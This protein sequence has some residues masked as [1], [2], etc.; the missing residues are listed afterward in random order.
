MMFFKG[1][2]AAAVF[3]AA[4]F[5]AVKEAKAADVSLQRE[6]Q[7]V[8]ITVQVQEDFAGTEAKIMA[9]EAG[10]VE[11]RI[12][13]ADLMIDGKK[14]LFR[15]EDAVVRNISVSRDGSDGIIRFNT[16]GINSAAVAEQLNL[17]RGAGRLQISIPEELTPASPANAGSGAAADKALGVASGTFSG[18]R[19]ATIREA[20]ELNKKVAASNSSMVKTNSGNANGP[21]IEPA[22]TGGATGWTSPVTGPAPSVGGGR[23]S[24]P[25]S[26]IPV[27]SA[28]VGEKKQASTGI[29][30]L[31]ITLFVL[32][33][34][35]GA[36]IFALKKWAIRRKGNIASPTKIQV[37]TQHYLGPKKS[38]AIIQVAG[39]ALLIGVTDQNISMLKTL[40]LIDDEVPGVVPKNFA[41]QMDQE[42]F[43]GEDENFENF[44]MKGLGEVRDIVSARFPVVRRPGKNI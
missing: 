36:A 11:V 7:E 20:F 14:Q 33:V 32:C 1:S 37:L 23:E 31:V 24:R 17:Q 29:E 30:R 18:V 15:F 43:E 44:A 38:L 2:L 10:T 28:S 27:F 19:T 6:E 4:S 39:E 13:G 34:V 9:P 35:L 21:N 22:V 8:R 12:P 25:E 41:D 5:A 26:E 3:C 42:G 40:A 16:K